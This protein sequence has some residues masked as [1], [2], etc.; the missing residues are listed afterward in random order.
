MPFGLQWVF[1]WTISL[2][3]DLTHL[4]FKRLLRI[5][6]CFHSTG[7]NDR[8]AIADA[9]D[10]REEVRVS[11]I[12]NELNA[13]EAGSVVEIDKREILLVAQIANPS[14]KR[15]FFAC[16]MI[17]LF[18][19][20]SIRRIRACHKIPFLFERFRHLIKSCEFAPRSLEEI[21]RS[22]KR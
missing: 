9:Y 13:A 8:S 16:I 5:R 10:L 3:G 4:Y 15:H 14:G 18:I 19:E 2:D 22:S 6:R 21:P 12:C 1:R 7:N 17:G 11:G 20:L